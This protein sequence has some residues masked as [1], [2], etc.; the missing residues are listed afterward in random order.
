[1][2]SDEQFLADTYVRHQG[3]TTSQRI[4]PDAGPERGWCV[5]CD[6][7]IAPKGEP[8]VLLPIGSADPEDQEKMRAG[9]WVS[10]RALIVHAACAG[11]EAGDAR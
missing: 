5:V 6:Q 2:P 11:R 7:E 8:V 3:P 4:F 10:A 1:M 9:R